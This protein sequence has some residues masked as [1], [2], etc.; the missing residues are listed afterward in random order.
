[1]RGKQA[2]KRTI[3]VDIRYSNATVAKF[4][5][6]VMKNGKKTTAQGIVYGAFDQVAEKTKLNPLEVFENALRNIT[7]LLEIRSRRVGGANYQIPY[8]VRGNRRH[9][10]AFTWLIGAAKARKGLPMA[11]KLALELI[12]ANNKEGAAIRKRD[13]VHRMAEANKAFAHFAR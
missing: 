12:D 13:D 10:L 1:M 11:K 4:I 8:P 7:P 3:P 6:Y 5:N 2:P 9:M